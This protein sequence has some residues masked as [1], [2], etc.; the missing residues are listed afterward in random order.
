MAISRTQ[1]RKLGKQ[2]L[3]AKSERIAKAHKCFVSANVK[4]IVAH[5]LNT[6]KPNRFEDGRGLFKSPMSNLKGL[7]HKARVSNNIGG[8][9]LYSQDDNGRWR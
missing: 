2:R 3:L 6:P 5:N 9:K 1:R 7:S 4:T 8:T